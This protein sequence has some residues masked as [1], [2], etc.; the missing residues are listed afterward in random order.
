[1]RDVPTWA[2]IPLGMTGLFGII[3]VTCC[4]REYPGNCGVFTMKAISFVFSAINVIL[5][6]CSA[7]FQ[8][9]HLITMNTYT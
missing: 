9:T 4:H 2:G 1:M 8:S 6:L 7:A 5:C 3:F